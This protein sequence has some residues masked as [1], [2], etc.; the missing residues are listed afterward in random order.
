MSPSRRFLT[1]HD[2][3]SLIREQELN[4]F[5]PQ[6]LEQLVDHVLV[7]AEILFRWQFLHKRIELLKAV[8]RDLQALAKP[9]SEPERNR[10]GKICSIS[11][12]WCADHLR[13]HRRRRFMLT[14]RERWY[15][16]RSS[17]MLRLWTAAHYAA[18]CNMSPAG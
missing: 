12:S 15:T 14:L 9:I 10:L 8:D 5:Q 2:T 6:F 16:P 3:H 7:Y 1:R 11:E 4:L 17:S 13:M 18:L